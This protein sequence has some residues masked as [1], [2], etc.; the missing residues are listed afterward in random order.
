MQEH[1][2]NNKVTIAKFLTRK[3]EKKTNLKII[4]K[5]ELQ[6]NLHLV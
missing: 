1:E 2:I 4:D 6:F 5:N 3:L